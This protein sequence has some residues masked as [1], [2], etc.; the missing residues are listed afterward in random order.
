MGVI[1]GDAFSVKTDDPLE[2]Q[3]TSGV[4][5]DLVVF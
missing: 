4:N 1:P 3:G 2:S 5:P